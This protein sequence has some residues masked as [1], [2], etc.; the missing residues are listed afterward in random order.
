MK[1]LTRL[2]IMALTILAVAYILP[3]IVISE[4]LTFEGFLTALIAA[5][6]LGVVNA[7]LGPILK[8]LTLPINILTLGLFTFVINAFM[9]VIVA[10]VIPGF[11]IMDF[12]SAF[13]GAFLISVVSAIASKAIS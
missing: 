9:L 6:I 5:F 12:F 1:F 7:V 8:T 4:G 11:Q 13:L 3:G 2:I 10:W